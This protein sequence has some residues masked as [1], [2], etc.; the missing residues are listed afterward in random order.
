M[1][2]EATRGGNAWFPLY[3]DPHSDG[4]RLAR[5]VR[6]R[7]VRGVWDDSGDRPKPGKIYSRFVTWLAAR[8]FAD[9]PD[10]QAVRVRLDQVT[11]RVPGQATLKR[12]DKPRHIRERRRSK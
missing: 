11:V 2:I 6:Y 4:S 7:R 10:I 8:V 9:H 5:T 3:R 12:P 1:V